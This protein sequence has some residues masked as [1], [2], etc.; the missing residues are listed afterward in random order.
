MIFILQFVEYFSLNLPYF[1]HRYRNLLVGLGVQPASVE[2]YYRRSQRIEGLKHSHVKGVRDPTDYIPEGSIFLTGFY[3]DERGNRVNLSDV[4]TKIFIT[5]SPCLEPT[6]CKFVPVV[7]RKPEGMPKESWEWLRSMKFGH[8]IFGAKRKHHEA[9]PLPCIIGDSDLDGDDFFICFDKLLLVELERIFNQRQMKA[10]ES[11]QKE[12]VRKEKPNSQRGYKYRKGSPTW[13]QE[14][15][16]NMLDF[17][18]RANIG[19]LTGRLFKASVEAAENSQHG[20][21]DPDAR[22]YAKAFKDSLDVMKHGRKVELP[23]RLKEKTAVSM[24]D[25]V[26]WTK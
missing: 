26:H 5:R 24:H 16:A 10:E 23:M 17:S 21:W 22:A 2:A 12:Q 4:C 1:R 6:D 8:V 14:A 3:R 20:I 19:K 7:S 11:E 18:N 13:L 25:S 15:Q 9:V